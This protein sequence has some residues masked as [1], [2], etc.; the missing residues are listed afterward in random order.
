[1][2]FYK[3]GQVF[4]LCFEQ[5]LVERD[6][7]FVD[8]FRARCSRQINDGDQGLLGLVQMLVVGMLCV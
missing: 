5:C 4:A 6:F 8:F 7:F 3:V 2:N 1:M